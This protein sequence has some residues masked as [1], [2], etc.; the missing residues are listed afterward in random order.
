M[1]DTDLN[2]FCL[3]LF[4]ELIIKIT[5]RYLKMNCLLIRH[6]I[7]TD[8]SLTIHYQV[9]CIA[10][11]IILIRLT[12][13]F[14]MTKHWRNNVDWIK[15]WPIHNNK[16]KSKDTIKYIFWKSID[17]FINKLI[18]FPFP[19]TN[20]LS[21]HPQPLREERNWSK[22]VSKRLKSIYYCNLEWKIWYT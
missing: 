7:F 15:S 16:N 17:I 20:H 14:F 22:H 21:L 3:S 5:L 12:L 2:A 1:S 9:S 4:P 13:L 19:L 11:G 8:F 18:L 6:N 10:K